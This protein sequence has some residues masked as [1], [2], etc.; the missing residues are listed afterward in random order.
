MLAA[1]MEIP[2]AARWYPSFTR[3]LGFEFPTKC[4]L[5][6]S[7][8]LNIGSSSSFCLMMAFM[9]WTLVCCSILSSLGVAREIMVCDSPFFF[10]RLDQ[11]IE[12]LHM[13]LNINKPVCGVRNSTDFNVDDMIGLMQCIQYRI[14]N[15]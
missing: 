7:Q 8:W 9:I 15:F 12:R 3:R 2:L 1:S 10:N 13:K 14:Y 4:I 11:T 6:W 5:L